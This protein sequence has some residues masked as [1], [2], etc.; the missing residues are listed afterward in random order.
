MA[1]AAVKVTKTKVRAAR[2]TVPVDKY[3]LH[4]ST[5]S[6]VRENMKE[7]GH[8]VIENRA[9]P[10]FRDGMKPVQRRALFAMKKLGLSHTG[11]T[12]K[13]ARI[14]G[15]II[16]RYNPHGDTSAYDALVGLYHLRYPLVEA[17]GNFGDEL[18]PAG[19]Y[20]YTEAKFTNLHIPTFACLETAEMVP[21]FDA[22]TTEPLVLS[23]RLPLM[24]MNGGEGIA[25]GLSMCIPSHNLGELVPALIEVAKNTKGV[26][27]ADV[28]KHVRGPDFR[29]GGVLVSKPKE[30]ESVYAAGYG[31]LE[32]QCDYEVG[33]D[34]EGRTTIKVVG[35]PD[36]FSIQGFINACS[37]LQEAGSVAYVSHDCEKLRHK[38]NYADK[39]GKD[40]ITILVGLNNKTALTAV[41]KKL[42]CRQTYQFYTTQRTQDGIELKSH[43][44]LDIMKNWIRW[45]KGEETKVLKLD[46]SKAEKSLW[47]ETTRLIAMQPKHID[48][49]ADALK[50]NKVEFEDYLVKHLKVTIEQAKFISE[51]KVG[52]LRKANIPEQEA[53][54][55]AIKA[56]IA[57]I[58]DDLEHITRV[59]IKH[60]KALEPYF[61]ERRTKIGGR[62]KDTTTIAVAHTGDPVT[63]LASRDGKL[64]TNVTEKGSTTADVMSTSSYEGCVV[65]DETGLTSVLSTTEC[66]GKAGPA[67]K[68]LVGIAPAEAENLLVVGRNGYCVKMPGASAHKQS[69]F[70]AIKGTTVLAGFGVNPTSQV[71]VWGKKDGEFA[72]IR[73]SK[74]KEVRKNTAG[75]KLVPFKPV[76]AC[77]VHEKQALYTDDASKIAVMKAGDVELKQRLYVVDDRNIVIYKSGRRK[78]FD[79]AATVKEIAKDRANVRFVY[80][81]CLPSASDQPVPEKSEKP[82]RQIKV[83]KTKPKK[84]SVKVTRN[85]KK[86]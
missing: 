75:Q 10:D 84:V 18:S 1:K 8:Y 7:Y 32:F 72:C 56:E 63:M 82:G 12:M 16:G 17:P 64:F 73:A 51:L 35:Y 68:A 29:R 26:T 57:K 80:P 4:Y 5:G 48:I 45:R 37:K 31:A 3:A 86:K 58:K 52:N 59:V 50:Q 44:F 34:E 81:A 19:A 22:T 77:L 70:N 54:I 13:C 42:T 49:I 66:D 15:D 67:Y 53:K 39:N 11:G 33:K 21:N 41:V 78:F 2:T 85:T 38:D 14:V 20:R 74:I 43:N 65:F 46:L 6:L 55:K 28:M 79:R 62:I 69:E 25:V 27:L 24:L 40:L 83:E 76:R 36:C 47:N 23:T 9:V 60:L 61:D 71:L 30:I